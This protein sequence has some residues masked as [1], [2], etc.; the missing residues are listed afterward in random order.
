VLPPYSYELVKILA[1]GSYGKVLLAR[2]V[3]DAGHLP[4]QVAFKVFMMSITDQ[5]TSD[6]RDAEEDQ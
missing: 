3:I 4:L 1:E 5:E 2:K 6:A